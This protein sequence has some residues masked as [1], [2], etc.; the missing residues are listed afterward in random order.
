MSSYWYSRLLMQEKFGHTEHAHGS[1]GGKYLGDIVYGAN[2]GIITTFAVVSGAAGASL[3]PGVVIILG[4]ASLIA[5][6]I[7]MGL[8]NYLAIKSR[9][10][11]ERAERAREEHE[12]EA[13]PAEER[14]EVIKVLE[15]WHIPE[16]HL[17]VVLES[18]TKD[19]KRWVDF[20]MREELGIIEDDSTS[21]VRHG[22][23]T[24]V[25]FLGAGILPLLPFLF[26]TTTTHAFTV[27]LGATGVALFAVGASRSLVTQMNWLKSGLEMLL[28]GTLAAASAYIVGDLVSSVFGI[29]L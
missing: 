15:S 27:S 4:L 1:T 8:S 19:K 12:I 10:E 22:L 25:S 18:I 21:A 11:Y 24:T 2:D 16:T 7:S 14:A 29:R 17:P 3:A 5:D 28:V 6:S 23:I 20:M 9:L 26:T 13:F